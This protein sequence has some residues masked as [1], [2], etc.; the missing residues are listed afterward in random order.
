[1]QSNELVE[2][3]AKFAEVS[4][5]IQVEKKKRERSRTVNELTKIC[6]EAY[7]LFLEAEERFESAQRK[8]RASR[9]DSNTLGRLVDSFQY[10]ESRELYP[11]DLLNYFSKDNR[12]EAI[13]GD[14]ESAYQ[15]LT[16]SMVEGVAKKE[17][18]A[19]RSHL[20]YS[21]LALQNAI[22]KEVAREDRRRFYEE[23]K[24]EIKKK[25]TSV[26]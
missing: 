5:L 13:Q 18:D 3:Q 21:W 6:V 26:A 17:F 14:F 4:E 11:V 20:Q 9:V 15:Y 23:K 7:R 12:H 16:A 2:L 8:V 22:R 19:T 1:M 10:L 25:A 24:E